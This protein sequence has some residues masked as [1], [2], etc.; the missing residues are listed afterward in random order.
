[1]VIVCWC[2]YFLCIA[3]L[4][5]DYILVL[6]ISSLPLAWLPSR[7]NPKC[8]AESSLMGLWD[9]A[10]DLSLLTDFVCQN[11]ALKLRLLI[12]WYCP[13]AHVHI[14]S[15][16]FTRII[17]FPSGILIYE[18]HVTFAWNNWI[19]I[20]TGFPHIVC[21]K[22][23]IIAFWVHCWAVMRNIRTLRRMQC[24]EKVWS[25]IEC[26]VVSRIMTGRMLENFN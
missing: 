13:H 16:T 1:M 12:F 4:A 21:R 17:G 18:K 2:V 20:K 7:R 26:G 24:R 3:I 25:V 23:D 5:C 15:G 19:I 9:L 11:G 10:K 8:A 22:S 6:S 14:S